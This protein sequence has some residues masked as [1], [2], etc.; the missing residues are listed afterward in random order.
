MKIAFVSIYT[1]YIKHVNIIGHMHEVGQH[2]NMY[3]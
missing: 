3:N 2:I 1:L